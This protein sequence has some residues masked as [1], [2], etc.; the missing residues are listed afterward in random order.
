MSRV[1]TVKSFFCCRD[2]LF[3][4]LRNDAGGMMNFKS[5][6]QETKLLSGM[7]LGLTQW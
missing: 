7:C 1:I 5:V 2:L 3:L 6:D 4:T